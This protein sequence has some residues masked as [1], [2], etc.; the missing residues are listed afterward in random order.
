MFTFLYLQRRRLGFGAYFFFLSGILMFDTGAPVSDLGMS[1]LFA[2]ICTSLAAIGI[3]FF[4]SYR[5]V[6]EIVG[7][8]F[9]A[10]RALEAFNPAFLAHQEILEGAWGVILVCLGYTLLHHAIYGA[11]WEKTSLSLA[12]L[13]RSRFRAT[14]LP[15]KAWRHLVPNGSDPELHYSGTLVAFEPVGDDAAHRVQKIRVGK[16]QFTEIHV[17][18]T[19]DT[20]RD[21]FAYVPANPDTGEAVD[22]FHWSLSLTPA[23]M[24]ST[25]VEVIENNHAMPVNHALLCWFDDLGGQ[26]SHSMKTTLEDRNDPTLLRRLRRD[27]SEAV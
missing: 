17:R 4:P 8:T 20:G 2:L 14:V 21:R 6:W 19:Q 11:W 27:F 12:Y 24:G 13:C 9:L 26:V 25:D 3:Y 16:D 7:V 22:G 15:E 18:I 5:Q 10:I 23:P 1:A